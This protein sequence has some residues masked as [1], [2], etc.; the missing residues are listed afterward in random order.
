MTDV[1]RLARFVVTRTWDDIS[2]AARSELKIRVLDALGCALGALG[3]APIAAIR[4]QLDDFGRPLCA[5][6]GGGATAPDRAALDNG[7]LVRYLDF[8]DSYF[9]PD[10]TCRPSDNLAPVL[11]AAEYADASGGE[12]LTALA[13]SYQVQCRL[14]DEASVRAK[15][16]TTR[17]RAP[18][19]PPPARRRRC[20]STRPRR[21][22]RSRSP[23]Q[24]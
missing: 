22:T 5:L 17:R 16:S 6:I 12:L 8:N 7:A 20:A 9:A 19:R 14:S 3:A 13:V 2:E 15:G 4:A 1:E 21:R 23:A 11:A 10:E 18:T 24:R